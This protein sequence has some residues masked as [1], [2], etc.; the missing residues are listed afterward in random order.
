MNIN[1]FHLTNFKSIGADTQ[2]IKLKPITL[3]F[4]ANS[5]GKSSVIQS[6]LWQSHF[7]KTG[8]VDVRSPNKGLGKVDLGGFSQFT[9]KHADGQKITVQFDRQHAYE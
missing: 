2:E 5:S 3:L 4:G 1:S 6:L 8:E 9:H 7:L